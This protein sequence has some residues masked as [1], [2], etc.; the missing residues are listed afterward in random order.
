MSEGVKGGEKNYVSERMSE[1]VRETTLSLSQAPKP[2]KYV[3]EMA[4]QATFY[5]NRVLK[6]FKG[7]DE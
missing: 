1:C 7:K 4:D 5:G 3:K 6:D 2:V